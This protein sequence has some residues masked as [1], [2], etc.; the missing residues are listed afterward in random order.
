MGNLQFRGWNS[1]IEN[2]TSVELD[3]FHRD[4][5]SAVYVCFLCI[6]SY[7]VI[8]FHGFFFYTFPFSIRCDD[9]LQG[10]FRDCFGSCLFFYSLFLF[11][12]SGGYVE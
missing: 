8:F 2:S 5:Y 4:L 9:Q 11:N 7:G 1:S 12:I 3:S 10:F 6:I